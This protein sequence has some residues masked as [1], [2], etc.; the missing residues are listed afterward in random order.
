MKRFINLLASLVLGASLV[1]CVASGMLVTQSGLP[2]P[3]KINVLDSSEDDVQDV[4]VQ[5]GAN[6]PGYAYHSEI[7]NGERTSVAKMAV[8]SYGVVKAAESYASVQN[9]AN[10]NAANVANT[11]SNNATKQS[12]ATAKEATKQSISTTNAGVVDGAVK[13]NAALGTATKIKPLS[14]GP[15]TG[16]K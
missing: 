11:A 9:T 15:A 5:P 2:V 7:K 6:T 4:T 13:S 10:T 1:S 3:Y 12:I 16:T 8:T 14:L